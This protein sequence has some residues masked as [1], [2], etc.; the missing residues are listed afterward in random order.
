MRVFNRVNKSL[1]II[2]V[3][4]IGGKPVKRVLTQGQRKNIRSIVSR[5]NYNKRYTDGKYTYN[6][7]SNG[8]EATVSIRQCTKE[9]ELGWCYFW[10]RLKIN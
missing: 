10:V 8:E 2:S 3:E 9:N 1:Q 4:D 5:S 6:G 7:W